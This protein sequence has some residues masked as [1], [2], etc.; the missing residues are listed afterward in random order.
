MRTEIRGAMEDCTTYCTEKRFLSFWPLFV[1]FALS[2][3]AAT[4]VGER[5]RAICDR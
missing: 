5:G 3:R 2:T 1:G 4:V